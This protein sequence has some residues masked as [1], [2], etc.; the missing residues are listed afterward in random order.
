MAYREKTVR[1]ALRPRNG[2]SPHMKNRPHLGA[3]SPSSPDRVSADVAMIDR[4]KGCGAATQ[5]FTG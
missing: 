2:R 4:P 3:A 1:F 5:I